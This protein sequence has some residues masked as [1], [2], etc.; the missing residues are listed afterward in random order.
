MAANVKQLLHG[1]WKVRAVFDENDDDDDD[2]DGDN[3]DETVGL[4]PSL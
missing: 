4:S 3:N 1:H 2:D